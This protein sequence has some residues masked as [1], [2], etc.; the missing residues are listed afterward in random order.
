ML[1]KVLSRSSL[2]MRFT[3]VSFFL[4]AGI[5][6]ILIL[7]IQKRLELNALKQEAHDA[8]DQ[9][10]FILGPTLW[11]DDLTRPLAPSRYAFI[12]TLIRKQVLHGYTV[13]ARIYLSDGTV[14]YADEAELVGKK[15]PIS[16]ELQEALNDQ[17]GMEVSDLSKEENATERGQYSRLLEVYVPLHPVDAPSQVFGA[18]EIYN[19][20]SIVN[21]G[22]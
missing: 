5:A 20:L 9:V 22:I 1:R 19:D 4:M 16:D 2:L 8:A 18:C 6:I 12:D 3:L 14:I 15:F 11:M 21:P 17:V 13:H 7:G 10:A